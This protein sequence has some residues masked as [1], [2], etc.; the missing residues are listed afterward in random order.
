[1]HG[2]SFT[3]LLWQRDIDA[4]EF[5][6]PNGIGVGNSNLIAVRN[7]THIAGEWQPYAAYQIGAEL[8]GIGAA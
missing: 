5:L 4:L 3:L 8:R 2:L 6:R 7:R 1:M